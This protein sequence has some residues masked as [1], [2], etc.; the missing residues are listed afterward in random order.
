MNSI[1]VTILACVIIFLSTVLGSSLVYIV[2]G[3]L[4]A[5]VSNVVLGVASGIMV[6]AGIFGLLIPA[7][8]EAE[9]IYG[10]LSIIPVIIGFILGGIFLNILDKVVPHFHN[11]RNEDEGPKS[12]LAKQLKFF[13]AVMIHNIPEGLAVGFA[14]GLAL[15][16][17]SPESIASVLALAIGISIQNFPEGMAI[18]VPMYEQTGNKNKSF[19]Y[20]VLSGV[21]E[22]LFA[23]VGIFLASLFE[24]LLPWL[25]AFSAGA[26]IYVTIE[27]LLPAARKENH[28]HYGLW[29]FMIGFVIMLSLELLL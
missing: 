28:E 3:K 22:P 25:L 1:Q 2:R 12:N 26:M 19:L 29:A 24:P 15:Q 4:S 23:I 17:N 11:E 6:S 7:M 14:C 8:E 27:E 16:A 20:G 13:L 21:V 5:K 9:I 18:S 10:D